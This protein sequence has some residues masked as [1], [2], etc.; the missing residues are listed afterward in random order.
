[1]T[2]TMCDYP[3]FNLPGEYLLGASKAKND[4]PE[5]IIGSICAVDMRKSL[6]E[7]I[8]QCFGIPY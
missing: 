6:E 1:M 2:I 4:R 3:N 5:K 7:I 8:G